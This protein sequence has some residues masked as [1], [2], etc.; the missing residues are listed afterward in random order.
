MKIQ[1]FFYRSVILN[2]FY[3]IDKIADFMIES[4]YRV[5]IKLWS[6]FSELIC[7]FFFVKKSIFT[8]KN[9]QDTED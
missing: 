9:T 4:I 8:E 2:T 3:Y 7:K 1:Y 6:V 5:K